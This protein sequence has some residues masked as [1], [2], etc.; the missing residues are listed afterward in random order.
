VTYTGTAKTVWFRV[1][2]SPPRSAPVPLSALSLDPVIEPSYRVSFAQ[3]R[4]LG[5]L[6]FDG[7]VRHTVEAARDA[8]GADAAYALV[9]DEEG[10]LRVRG[11][12]GVAVP[13]ALTAPPSAMLLSGGGC[14]N[15]SGS[16]GAG[17]RSSPR[18]ASCCPA[19]SR[20]A[21]RSR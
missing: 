9:A 15:L 10:E 14:P 7:L 11:A 17:W 4:E 20:N 12:V 5:K 13:G 6:D 18:R 16:A 2:L 8:V 21:R 19:R 3:G 1:R